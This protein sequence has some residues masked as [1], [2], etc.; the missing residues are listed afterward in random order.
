MQIVTYHS[1]NAKPSEAWMAFVV[2]PN[3]STVQ[4]HFKAATEQ[5]AKD[6]AETFY[7]AE[8]ERQLKLCGTSAA[9]PVSNPV[10]SSEPKSGRGAGFVGSVWVLNRSTGHKARIQASE[11]AGYEANGYVR[12]GPRSK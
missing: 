6:N 9:E 12:G 4:V 1:T 5:S 11:L 3:G 7:I 8:K 10:V 2:L